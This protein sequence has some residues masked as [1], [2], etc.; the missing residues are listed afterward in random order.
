MKLT[1]ISY[2]N[3]IKLTGIYYDD[4]VAYV[5]VRSTND[6]RSQAICKELESLGARVSKKFT[7]DVTHVIYKEGGKRTR[8]KA[9]KRGVPLVSVLWIESCK[10]NQSHVSERLYPALLQENKGTPVLLTRLKKAKSMQPR[11]FEDDLASSAERCLK[12]RRKEE[13][14][15]LKSNENTPKFSPRLILA[16]DTQHLSPEMGFV[17]TPVRLTIPDTPPSMRQ[18]MERLKQG[19]I[20]A[21]GSYHI[22]GMN[23]HHAVDMVHDVSP[24]T[25]ENS[26][27]K[28]ESEGQASVLSPNICTTECDEDPV[29]AE[30]REKFETIKN[31]G[32]KDSRGKSHGRN[33]SPLQHL[34]AC[35]SVSESTKRKSLCSN[36][37]GNASIPSL[38]NKSLNQ[39]TEGMNTNDIDK[40]SHAEDVEIYRSKENVKDGQKYKEDNQKITSQPIVTENRKTFKKK[41]LSVKDTMNPPAILIEPTKCSQ[42]P[43][44]ALT[45]NAVKGRRG[46]ARRNSNTS[47]DTDGI[48]GYKRSQGRGNS[49]DRKRNLKILHGGD[50]NDSSRDQSN[51][52]HRQ[53]SNLKKSEAGGSKEDNSSRSKCDEIISVQKETEIMQSNIEHNATLLNHNSFLNSTPETTM[54]LTLST[55]ETTLGLSMSTAFTD[56]TM[57]S[58]F[59]PPRPSIDEFN[60]K[61]NKFRGIKQSIN[62]KTTKKENLLGSDTCHNSDCRKCE[63]ECLC[64]RRNSQIKTQDDSLSSIKRPT[65][66]MTSLHSYE[67]DVV[68]AV[69][70]KLGGFSITEK[71]CETTTHVVSGEPRRTLNILHGL[72]RGCW[73]I[74]NDWVLHSLEAGRWLKE[75]AFECYNDFPMCRIARKTREQ[76]LPIQARELFAELG[77]IFISNKTVPPR[78]HL[79]PLIKVC[80]GEVTNNLSKARLYLGSNFHPDIM[81]L[82][83]LWVLDCVTEGTLLPMDRY[84]SDKPKRENSPVY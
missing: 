25:S 71:V 41:L 50:D 52:K 27:S 82:K 56:T 53:N 67:Q 14:D 38:I 7:D 11:N 65:L 19:K 58:M 72:A 59:M 81:S 32:H 55:R 40:C 61:R 33:N 75:D 18:K 44:P 62:D 83:P 4:V 28:I 22:T 1:G 84:T 24:T 12:K 45:H 42:Y 48:I 46:R 17:R 78:K 66:V 3:D 79:I 6:N 10:H 31:L 30:V 43:S 70:K 80:G 37:N 34:S 64:E 15:K 63:N 35:Q 13:L 21:Q 5:E 73:I 60:L 26:V 76:G 69:V 74:S 16:L 2:G 77:H 36:C 39:C 68:I 49:G 8:N 9:Q 20:N 51:K 47:V 57:P 54:G 23:M 29:P